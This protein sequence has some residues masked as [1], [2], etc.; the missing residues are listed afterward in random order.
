MEPNIGGCTERGGFSYVVCKDVVLRSKD[1]VKIMS[2]EKY[3]IHV[4]KLRKSYVVFKYFFKVY[5]FLG[6]SQFRTYVYSL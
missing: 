2:S 1:R 6:Y 3:K 4:N 5:N